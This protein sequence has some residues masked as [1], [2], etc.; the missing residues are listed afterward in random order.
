MDSRVHQEQRQT[1][2]ARG[3]K[4][5]AEFREQRFVQVQN[6]T[7]GESDEDQRLDS[8]GARAACGRI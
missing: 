3:T 6:A 4:S 8:N 1:Q 7:Y 5:T 2:H